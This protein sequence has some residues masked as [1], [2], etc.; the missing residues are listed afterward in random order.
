[1]S[2]TR[3]HDLGGLELELRLAGANVN[4]R[5]SSEL[6]LVTTR[7]DENAGFEPRIP[8]HLLDGHGCHKPWVVKGHGYQLV[9]SLNVDA[10]LKLEDDAF[11]QQV[12]AQLKHSKARHGVV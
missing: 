11:A 2:G 1:M 8:E 3:L 5:I 6:K 12:A 9:V 10:V 4:L 7:K